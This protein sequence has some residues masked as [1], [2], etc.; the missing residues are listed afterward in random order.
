MRWWRSFILVQC[1]VAL[2]LLTMNDEVYHVPTGYLQTALIQCLDTT[3]TFLTNIQHNNDN[4]KIT[5]TSLKPVPNGSQGP[6]THPTTHPHL[7]TRN[8]PLTSCIHIVQPTHPQNSR[9]HIPLTV[10]GS[11]HTRTST[12]HHSTKVQQRQ[13]PH[14]T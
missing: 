14:R 10:H 4:F 5:N 6:H 7:H 11:W 2:P 1:H 8:Y 12:P 9:P 13:R 3:R